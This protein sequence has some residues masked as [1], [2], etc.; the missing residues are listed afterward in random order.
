MYTLSIN[1]WSVSRLL[2]A[3][4]RDHFNN[5]VDFLKEDMEKMSGQKV[6]LKIAFYK[7]AQKPAAENSERPKPETLIAKINTATVP[8]KLWRQADYIEAHFSTVASPQCPALHVVMT[9]R[10]PDDREFYFHA[11]PKAEGDTLGRRFLNENPRFQFWT[12]S[13]R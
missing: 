5:A 12:R 8:S 13:I 2:F 6:D 11:E 3:A 9:A 1:K 10:W 7:A 4:S